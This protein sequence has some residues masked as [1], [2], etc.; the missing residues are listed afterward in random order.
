[1]WTLARAS[2]EGALVVAAIW[3]LSRAL[4]LAPATRTLLWWCAAAKF[5]LA[6]VWTA[7]IAI[8]ILP[9]FGESLSPSAAVHGPRAVDASSPS[10]V[11]PGHRAAG[12][13][14]VGVPCARRGR[15]VARRTAARPR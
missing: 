4:T 13:I 3:A 5:V 7:P 6:L 8:P 9:T 14:A 15:I 1:M 2:L 11:Q 10:S 12:R